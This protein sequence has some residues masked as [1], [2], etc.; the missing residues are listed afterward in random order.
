MLILTVNQSLIKDTNAFPVLNLRVHGTVGK[1]QTA[2]VAYGKNG[3]LGSSPRPS[4]CKSNACGCLK[5]SKNF[6]DGSPSVLTHPHYDF[7]IEMFE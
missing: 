1:P 3:A 2:T 7:G 4:G 5:K 6:S